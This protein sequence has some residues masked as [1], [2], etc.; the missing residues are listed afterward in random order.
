MR[1]LLLVGAAAY[2]FYRMRSSARSKT[3][4]DDILITKVRAALDKVLE[5]SGEVDIQSRQ[6]EIILSGPVGDREIK[7]CLRAVRRISGVRNVVCRLRAHA[8]ATA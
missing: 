5:H 1:T 4:S 2:L 8:M 3:V 7:P 6:G